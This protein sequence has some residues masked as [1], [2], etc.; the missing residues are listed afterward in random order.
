MT[1]AFSPRHSPAPVA[2][3]AVIEGD[4]ASELRRF[5]SDSVHLT[6]TSPPYGSL[7][8]YGGDPFDFDR[9]AAHLY[10]V[11][12]P[13]GVLVWVAADACGDAKSDRPGKS[14]ESARQMLRFMD[15]G[16]TLHDTMVAEWPNKM[17]RQKY[18]YEQ[19]WDYMFVFCKGP[20]PRVARIRRVPCLNAGKSARVRVGNTTDQVG[21]LRDRS[22]PRRTVTV[23]ADK[24]D[25]NVW[26]YST[27]L[28]QTSRDPITWDHPAPFPEALA[29][30]HVLSWSDP[31]D[32]VLD[33]LCGS[34]TTLKMA[35]VEGRRFVGIEVCP[36]YA[37]IA[38]RRVDLY[39]KPWPAAALASVPPPP[40]KVRPPKPPKPPKPEFVWT[41]DEPT[42]D[43]VAF[44]K[45]AGRSTDAV[46]MLIGRR[47]LPA[48][49][50]GRSWAIP[51][52]AAALLRAP[53]K[54]VWGS[55][56][57]STARVAGH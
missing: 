17:P 33:P 48:R 50:V 14:G 5:P 37:D 22:G 40:P 46:R 38:R 18:R 51:V 27:G 30:D 11:T 23:G 45:L 36:Q 2:L 8:V 53:Q 49:K 31:G 7:R 41:A 54:R 15:L 13:G 19:V 39:R 55:P 32:V 21:P 56:A 44:A 16:F 10:R 35:A 12:A 42:T 1:R 34:G 9:I 3:D 6:V 29:R 25:G 57:V 4:A 28:Y 24:P 26:R 47:R 52:R 43:L 20:R